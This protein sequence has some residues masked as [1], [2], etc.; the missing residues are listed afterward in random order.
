MRVIASPSIKTVR[1]LK[2]KKIGVGVRGS[3]DDEFALRLLDFYGLKEKDVKL[4][5]VGRKVAQN[6]FANHQIDAIMLTYTRNN[7]RHLGP[8]F[9]ARPIGKSSHF[10][11]PTMEELKAFTL[12]WSF[13]GIDTG[14]EPDF[15]V[16]D[17]TGVYVPTLMALHKSVDEDLVYKMTK[18]IFE[19]WDDCIKALPWWTP[20]ETSP[21]TAAE[22][23]GATAK[24]FHPGA[25]RYY[26]EKGLIK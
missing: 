18:I 25:L 21:E 3:G 15:G 10:V 16:S 5:F 23:P 4:Q 9:A 26:K 8:V 17:L 24:A 7:H 20:D 1:D 13:Y 6:S 12:K 19:N 22:I 14:G 2:G 11:N